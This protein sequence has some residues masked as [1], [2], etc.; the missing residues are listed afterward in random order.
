[1]KNKG[2]KQNK[3]IT[4]IALVITI[5]VIL[6][7]AGVSINTLFGDNGLLTKAQEAVNKN[8]EAGAYDKVATEVFASYDNN[9]K[10]NANTL[11]SNIKAH[12]GGTATLGSNNGFPVTAIVDAYTFTID[13]QGNIAPKDGDG[14]TQGDDP[15]VVETIPENE[16]YV[17]YYADLNGDGEADGII[18]ADLAIGSGGEKKWNNNSDSMFQYDEVTEG[19][20]KY[21]LEEKDG[22]GF[23][24]YKEKMIKE[25]D[26]TSGIDRFYVMALKDLNKSCLWYQSAY[27][28][29]SNTGKEK[30]GSDNDFGEGKSN[31]TYWI[32]TYNNPESET[33]YGPQDERDMWK[34]IQDKLTDSNG[35]TWFIPS[36]SECSA[37]GYMCSEKVKVTF[38]VSGNYYDFSLG[39]FWTSTLTNSRYGWTFFCEPGYIGKTV[40]DGNMGVRLSTTF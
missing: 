16:S 4:L 39:D 17:G 34:V 21:V 27:E 36:K 30:Q 7:L 28:K 2:L 8:T 23:G 3:G 6:I 29:V 14:G 11:Q 26:K 20:K 1:M 38:D 18:Y 40:L 32:N 13:S 24:K 33:K 10:L 19:L 5:I 9:G 37:F 35:K 31:T 15:T 22:S 12:T 25:V